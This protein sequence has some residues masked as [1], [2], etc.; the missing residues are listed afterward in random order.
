MP[1]TVSKFD[2]ATDEAAVTALKQSVEGFKN[3]DGPSSHSAL[4]GELDRD[5]ALKPQLRHC[6]HHL[7]LMV[8]SLNRRNSSTS[9]VCEVRLSDPP[10]SDS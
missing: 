8:P 6:E 1:Q 10:C 2:A 5:A 3:Y 4:F 9:Q 7:S